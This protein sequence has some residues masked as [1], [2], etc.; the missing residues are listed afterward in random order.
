VSHTIIDTEDERRRRVQGFADYVWL[1][2]SG[3]FLAL[4]VRMIVH[5]NQF[6]WFLAPIW[7]FALLIRLRYI[8]TRRKLPG[9]DDPGT[10]PL[11]RLI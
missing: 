9:R 3:F 10:G 2:L 5:H 6:G 1:S 7:V 4:S 8:L 11:M